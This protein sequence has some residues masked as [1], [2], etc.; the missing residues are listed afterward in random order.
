[1]AKRILEGEDPAGIP[2]EFQ[3]DLQLYINARFSREMGLIPPEAL[4]KKAT[5]V[6]E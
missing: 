1:M 4:L 5:K 2:V 3:E 6:Y